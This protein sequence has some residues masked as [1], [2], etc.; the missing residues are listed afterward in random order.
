M[1]VKICGL[2]QVAQAV[3]IARMGV[4][5]VG[6]VCVPTSRRYVAPAQQRQLNQALAAYPVWRVGVFAECP[7]SEVIAAVQTQGFTGVQLHGQESPPYCQA[8]R[9]ACPDVMIIKA[10]RVRDATSLAGM[11]PYVP[12][13]DRFLLDAY[14]PQHLG[15]TGRAWDWGLLRH[16]DAPLPWWLAG[17][18]TPENCRAAIAQTRPYGI[19]VSSGVEQTPGV[20]DMQRVAQLLQGI[21]GHEKTPRRG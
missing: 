15:G 9:A 13:V 18:I 6:I 20:K 8:L 14:D 17:G 7:L 16:L 4:T 3:A 10:L 2:T 12:W 1:E 19:D 21:Y 11:A 5:A